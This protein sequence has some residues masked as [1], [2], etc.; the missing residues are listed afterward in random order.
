MASNVKVHEFG[1]YMMQQALAAGIENYP[2]FQECYN[3]TVAGTGDVAGN[4]WLSSMFELGEQMIDAH[5][6]LA[7]EGLINDLNF[8]SYRW[9]CVRYDSGNAWNY[10]NNG[11]SNN[12]GFANELAVRPVTKLRN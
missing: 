5:F 8:A 3:Y 9:S 12:N 4:W 6:D 1:R 7:N 10:N 2:A 11:M